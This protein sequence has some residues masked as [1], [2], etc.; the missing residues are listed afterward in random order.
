MPPP[1]YPP[2]H[3]STPPPTCR[4]GSWG[5]CFTYGI[6]FGVCGLAALGHTY[7]NDEAIRRACR[8]ALSTRFL[9][10]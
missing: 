4:Y 2:A 9:T 6:W 1:Q 8:C 3:G 5:V 10:V 7:Q